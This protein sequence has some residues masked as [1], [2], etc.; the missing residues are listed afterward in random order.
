MGLPSPG[1]P[2]ARCCCT[3]PI[4]PNRPEDDDPHMDTAV[5]RNPAAVFA[6]TPTGQE[7]IQRRALGLPPL[8]RRLLVLV[9]GRRTVAELAA[10]V[11]DQDAAAWLDVLLEKACIEAIAAPKAAAAP[12][13]AQPSRPAPPPPAAADDP[14]AGLPPPEYRSAQQVEM[15][16]NFMINTINTLLEQNSRLTL[17]EQIFASTG[18]AEL[19]LHYAAWEAAISGSWMGARRLPELRKKLF[20]VL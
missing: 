16:R 4:L 13:Q 3:T 5:A 6:K 1:C 11:P 9:D 10:F 15:A 14:L 19:R 20:A 8:A 12:P 18:A 2:A 7:E 17:V